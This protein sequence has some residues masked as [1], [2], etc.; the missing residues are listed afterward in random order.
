MSSSDGDDD[1]NGDEEVKL[2]AFQHDDH[3][4]E[5]VLER[6]S[7]DNER[8]YSSSSQV[9]E[10]SLTTTLRTLFAFPRT[11]GFGRNIA[12]RLVQALFA[13]RPLATT[14]AAGCR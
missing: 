10:L 9:A 12:L 14:N 3:I 6:V 8:Q 11:R 13:S 2:T 5:I 4:Q 7:V 1:D